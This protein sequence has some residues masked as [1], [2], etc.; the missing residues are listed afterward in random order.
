MSSSLVNMSGP[1]DEAGGLEAPSIRQRPSRAK[2]TKVQ[3]SLLVK[4]DEGNGENGVFPFVQNR[5][6]GFPDS[7]Q[8]SLSPDVVSILS[9]ESWTRSH[10][11]VERDRHQYKEKAPIVKTQSVHG[12]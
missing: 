2:S 11:H 6:R 7:A 10:P 3:V 9:M 1:T 4:R 8:G 5:H 12:T